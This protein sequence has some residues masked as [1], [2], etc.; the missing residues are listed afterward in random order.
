MSQRYITDRFLPD[1]AID[2]VDEAAAKLNIEVTSKPQAIDELERKL[3]QLQM[4]RMSIARD[5][6]K[7]AIS[8]VAAIDIQISQLNKESQGLRQS[9]EAEKAGVMK[10]QDLKN[11]LD[12]AN[13]DL[14]KFER[15]SDL[16]S[17]AKLKYEVIPKLKKELAEEESHY[18]NSTRLMLRDTVGEDDI[19]AIVSSW[20]GVPISKLLQGELQKLLH[21]QE[22]LEKRVV[23][24]KEACRVVA[25]AIQRSRAGM[26]DPN[27]PIATLAFLGPT[28]E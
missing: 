2:L 4:E 24:Q 9:W 8:R 15:S 18:S 25:E 10:L 13:T 12:A 16:L 26:S 14:E 27:R 19:A 5:E 1:K 28:G 23:G 6:G 7:E 17:A 3:I 21:L 11:K 20:T 22:E